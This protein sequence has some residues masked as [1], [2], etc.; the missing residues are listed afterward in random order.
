M[1][2]VVLVGVFVPVGVPVGVSVGVGVGVTVGVLVDV[3][4]GVV[5]LKI[6]STSI[7]KLQS[8]MFTSISKSQSIQSPK[9]EI[10]NS[11]FVG[12]VGQCSGSI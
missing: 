12:S 6:T 3:G 1:G 5:S 9:T 2:V 8:N 7:S 4:V 11:S 10:S